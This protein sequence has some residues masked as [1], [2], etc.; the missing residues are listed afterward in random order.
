MSFQLGQHS[1]VDGGRLKV[2][3]WQSLPE[4]LRTIEIGNYTSIAS[5]VVVFVD[6]N[7]RMDF[8]STFPF[9]EKLGCTQAPPSV[10]GKSA[11]RIGHDVWIGRNVTIMSGVRI[12]DG[13]VVGYGSVVTRNVEPYS[14]VAG[15]PAR[16]IKYRFDDAKTIAELRD[17]EWWHLPS[18]MVLQE[19]APITDDVQAFIQR[20]NA[21]KSDRIS[22]QPR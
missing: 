21:L 11:P 2:M 4:N 14:I 3:D 10:C 12:G 13:A 18:E 15:N 9:R 19:L 1:Y 8:A 7:H 5:D 22:E 17:T 16:H 6:G 20:A